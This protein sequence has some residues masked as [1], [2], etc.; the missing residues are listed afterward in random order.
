MSPPR[1]AGGAKGSE[2][3]SSLYGEEQKGWLLVWK[4]APQKVSN[5]TPSEQG[6]GGPQGEGPVGT[7]HRGLN[8]IRV[9]LERE[10]GWLVQ[11]ASGLC[12]QLR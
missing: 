6:G 2:D 11:T 5:R 9:L 8:K 7:P 10:G 1:Q 12:R 3:L 4:V